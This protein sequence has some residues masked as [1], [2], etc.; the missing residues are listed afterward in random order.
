MEGEGEQ[1]ARGL[2]VAVCRE[3]EPASWAK[4]RGLEAQGP[5]V[6]GRPFFP[7]PE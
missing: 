6:K 5:R 2:R 1:V 7:L 4:R 3:A